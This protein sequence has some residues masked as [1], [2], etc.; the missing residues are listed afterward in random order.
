[1]SETNASTPESASAARA[2]LEARARALARP[3]FREAPADVLEV[4]IFDLAGERWAMESQYAHHVMRLRDLAALP[5]SEA[6][7]R[8]VTGWRGQLLIVLDLRGVLGL[9]GHGLD[10]LRHVIVVGRDRPV[11]GI[12][13]GVVR[14]VTTIE[15]KDIR[16][17]PERTASRRGD[18]VR[19]ITPE[20]VIVLDAA[21]LI[22]HQG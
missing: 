11:F 6:P 10:D 2:L 3:I 1:M 13:A 9:P 4:L 15:T 14:E 22:E 16:P 21:R 12:L 20:A 19:G 17:A 7:V 18:V 5:G 8:G